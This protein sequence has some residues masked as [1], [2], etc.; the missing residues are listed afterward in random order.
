ML[1]HLLRKYNILLIVDTS[2]LRSLKKNGAQDQA[3]KAG[4]DAVT[5]LTMKDA[6]YIAASECI[7]AMIHMITD[8]ANPAH[9]RRDL[10][11]NSTKYA[12]IGYKYK[13]GGEGWLDKS[14]FSTTEF[15]NSQSPWLNG[16]PDWNYMWPKASEENELGIRLPS[17]KSLE[18]KLAVL[19]LAQRVHKGDY[20]SNS[21]STPQAEFVSIEDLCN[22]G[23]ASD[24][25]TQLAFIK[26]IKQTEK[27]MI[28]AIY[29]SAC[30]IKWVIEEAK[31]KGCDFN[32]KSRLPGDT[33]IDLNDYRQYTPQEIND[34]KEDARYRQ[35]VE[36]NF[37]DKLEKLGLID[38]DGNMKPPNEWTDQDKSNFEQMCHEDGV[39]LKVDDD[40]F[41]VYGLE[42][43]DTHYPE[44]SQ[45]FVGNYDV[46]MPSAPA[47]IAAAAAMKKEEEKKT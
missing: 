27:M 8:I 36:D 6:K 15:K 33:G 26:T 29:Y 11:K 34:Y 1:N 47:M 13:L 5:L 37:S 2:T 10:W 31:A 44:D 12:S 7:G 46:A 43:M 41:Q 17:I 21:P 38:E 14:F 32:W 9:V 22:D 24:I 23:K 4:K 30:A 45:D 3:Q 18:P 28:W 19:K 16:G 35:W 40:G 20:T 42:D 25:Q 39:D